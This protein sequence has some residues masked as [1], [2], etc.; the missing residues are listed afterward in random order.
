MGSV[1]RE[2]G[3]LE[4][5]VLAA[6]WA[7]DAPLTAGEVVDALG[8]GLAYN[9]VQTILTRLHQK[10]AVR[11]QLAGRAHAYTPVLDEAGLAARR[12]RAM[13]DRGG[14]HAAILTRFVGTLSPDEE[15]TLTQLLH[16]PGQPDSP[17]GDGVEPYLPLLL[18]ALFGALAPVIARRLP[19]S[20]ATWLLSIGGLVAAAGSVAVLGFLAFTL[21][22]RAPLLATQGHWSPTALRHADPV[23][24]PVEVA[25]TLALAAVT[26]RVAAVAVRRSR[27][28]LDAHRLAAALPA[29]GADLT[30]IADP[31]P[32]AYAVPGRPGRIVASVGLLRGLD[33]A[34]RRAVLAHERSHLRHHHHAH[35]TT[36][37]LAAAAN[38]LLRALPAA[39]T[40]ATERWADEDAAR[41]ARRE[42]VAQALINAASTD[43]SRR[44]D[45][46]GGAGRGDRA[47][48]RPSTRPAGPG[49]AACR[50]GASPR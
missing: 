34:Q 16:P 11:R 42:T 21:L 17:G 24:V 25:A 30:V 9:T 2:P 8:D 3:G 19:P 39:V 47:D 40:L 26:V 14:D 33:A 45:T 50:D 38:P 15:R 41:T 1:R 12:M 7:A 31:V 44:L 43:P 48:R 4:A 35:H 5:E 6:L 28:V 10:G 32:C 49:A 23:A 13:L 20:I 18:A 27:A 22:G 36:V 37:R 29:R 46:G